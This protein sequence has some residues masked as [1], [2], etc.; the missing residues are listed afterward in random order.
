MNSMLLFFCCCW[1]FVRYC[2][3]IVLQVWI[4]FY[5]ASLFS[6]LF[7]QIHQDRWPHLPWARLHPTEECTPLCWAQHLWG[8]LALCTLQSAPWVHRWMAWRHRS[9][10][11][12]H[13]WG[14]TLWTH[15]A[16]ATAPVSAPRWDPCHTY[17][18]LVEHVELLSSL[19]ICIFILH[20]PRCIL[21]TCSNAIMHIYDLS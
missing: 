18:Q 17:T 13:P 7:Q 12:A 6:E 1:L 9:L 20:P 21:N 14:P 3:I 2:A 8:P 5:N 4:F 16:W 11:L 15:L 10:L 19:G